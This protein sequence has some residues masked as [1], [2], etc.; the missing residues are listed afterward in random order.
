[1]S[2]HKPIPVKKDGLNFYIKLILQ[3]QTMNEETL[4]KYAIEKMKDSKPKIAIDTTPSAFASAS[5]S[6]SKIPKFKTHVFT[7]KCDACLHGDMQCC[8]C[9][10]WF[11][12]G[13]LV[14]CAR[15]HKAHWCASC[16]GIPYGTENDWKTTCRECRRKVPRKD[17]GRLV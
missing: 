11:C 13:Q 12:V 1:M 7:N 17:R 16:F 15:C 10:G 6:S 9:H 5:A 14:E 8:G 2:F 4:W 3:Q